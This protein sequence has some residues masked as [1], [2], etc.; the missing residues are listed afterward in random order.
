MRAS[1]R[2]R[3]RA[4]VALPSVALAVLL[5][6]LAVGVV[7]ALAGVDPFA[8]QGPHVEHSLPSRMADRTAFDAPIEVRPGGLP[9]RLASQLIFPLEGWLLEIAFAPGAPAPDPGSL[10]LELELESGHRIARWPATALRR[11]ARGLATTIDAASL[12][13]EPGAVRIRAWSAGGA[14]GAADGADADTNTFADT[15]ERGSPTTWAEVRIELQPRTGP[16]AIGRGQVLHFDFE[17]DRNGDG[18]PD[19]LRDLEAFGLASPE[20]PILARRVARRVARTAL[21]RAQRAYAG[22]IDPIE[23]EPIDSVAIELR[24]EDGGD[25]DITRICVGGGDPSGGRTVGN[26]RFDPGNADRRSTECGELPATGLF[27]RALLAYRA[28]PLFRATFDP[29]QPARGGLPVGGHAEDAS[30]LAGTRDAR[31]S[32]P[33]IGAR[34]DILGEAID[35]FAHAL[36][37]IMAHEAAHALGL[38]APGNPSEGGLY[39]GREGSDAYHRIPS[40]TDDPSVSRDGDGDGER[41]IGLMSSGPALSFAQLAGR[42]IE[43]ELVF[44]PLSLAYLRDDILLP[45]PGPATGPDA[46]TALR[47]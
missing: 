39:G 18:L 28:D 10:Q 30:I 27:P 25:G 9:R 23:L 24:L 42:G 12:A 5:L 4:A 34:A 29:L 46:A 16:A 31:F 26:L 45:Q 47:H 8:A 17:I 21:A 2:H 14:S 1:P 33:E 7:L 20:H 19:F 38:V 11:T 43:G 3:T 44:D 32:D 35:V 6:A 40:D 37:S 15:G 13:L 22:P 41:P 36:G